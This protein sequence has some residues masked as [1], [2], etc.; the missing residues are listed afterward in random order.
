MGWQRRAQDGMAQ[1]LED[2]GLERLVRAEDKHAVG[3]LPRDRR[4]KPPEELPGRF[5]IHERQVAGVSAKN[6]EERRKSSYGATTG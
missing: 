3:D 5:P 6:E 4:P 1:H 2:L